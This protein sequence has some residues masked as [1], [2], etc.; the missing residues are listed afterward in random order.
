[1][2][3]KAKLIIDC[4]NIFGLP[5]REVDDG[6][7]LS[8]LLGQNSLN[9]L[10]ITTTFGNSSIKCVIAQTRELLNLLN[11]EHIPVFKGAS[12]ADNA[13]TEASQF[14]VEQ[15][16]QFPNQITFLLI[17]PTTNLASAQKLDASFFSKVKQVICL[18]GWRKTLWFARRTLKEVNFASDPVSARIVLTAECPVDIIDADVCLQ[19]LFGKKELQYINRSV[20]LPLK[21]RVTLTLWK[22][23]W[24]CHCFSQRFC[25]WDLVA[26]VY[27]L[28]K[29]CFIS[30][31]VSVNGNQSVNNSGQLSLQSGYFNS[32]I[33]LVSHVISPNMITAELVSGLQNIFG[34]REEKVNAG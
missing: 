16:N 13:Y 9:I 33:R 7:A 19:V 1:M 24:F 23:A 2:N 15:V 31:P 10:G 22:I 27:V 26:A 17:G 21:Y 32:N 30:H 34:T 6:L 28:N 20:N 8:Y 5:F 12:S 29:E 3:N 18:G 14:L 4:D 25:P 11:V